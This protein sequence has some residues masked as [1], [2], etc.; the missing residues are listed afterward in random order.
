MPHEPLAGADPGYALHQLQHALQVAATSDDAAVRQSAAAKV[1][2]WRAVLDGMASGHLTVGSR[3]PVR[4]T[5]AWVTLEVAHGGFATGRYLAEQPLDDAEAARLRELPTLPGETDRERLN[6]WY[7]SDAG[8]DELI[9]AMESEKYALDLPEHAA[10]LVVAL[11]IARGRHEQ[12]LDLV[13]DLR[14]LL[15]RLRF[16]PRLTKRVNAAGTLVHLEPIGVVAEALRAVA[17]PKQVR[18]M[19][20]AL[21]VWNPLYDDLVALWT[22]TVD[23]DLPHLVQQDDGP[24]V[25]GGWPC[26]HFPRDW[27]TRR[28]DWL[29]RYGQALQD[30]P[31]G[32]RH[33]HP[34]SNFARLRAALEECPDGSS[35]LSARDAG[36]VRRA[37]ANT[38]TS[39]G[40]PGSERRAALRSMQAQVAARPTRSALAHVVAGRLDRFPADGGLP[41]LD[42][43]T[44]DVS[45]EEL[46]E[47]AADEPIPPE[48][49]AKLERA[50][51]ASV[52]ELVE[53][54]VISSGDVLARVLPQITAHYVS[55]G[56]SDRTVASL[57]AQAYASFRRRRSLLLLN[58]EHQVRFEELPWN[59]CA[60]ALPDRGRAH[61]RGF[62]CRA[63]LSR[64][65]GASRLPPGDPAE[66]APT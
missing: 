13:A 6:L 59:S 42:P 63:A 47:L 52:D 31:V 56:I 8:Q 30:S 5:P 36:W 53:R 51:E 39:D 16:T 58:L 62:S 57:H 55:A 43:L 34:K 1:D 49:A 21:R 7:L 37:L 48:L 60:P 54:G 26:R 23:G 46:P 38:L 25:D 3:T 17:T 20:E 22:D 65:P 10:L 35:G 28:A 15:H 44:V 29:S 27:S 61:G 66:P 40:V 41:S 24:R 33:Q 18:T 2:R 50:L 64:A 11:L 4:D 14:P 32:T 12:A 45:R 19:H 9:A